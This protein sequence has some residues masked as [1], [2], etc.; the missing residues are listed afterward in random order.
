[1]RILQGTIHPGDHPTGIGTFSQF[2]CDDSIE[3][4][5]NPNNEHSRKPEQIYM[6]DAQKLSKEYHR[7]VQTS[8]KRRILDSDEESESMPS[9]ASSAKAKLSS[10]LNPSTSPGEWLTSR[11]SE[12]LARTSASSGALA[13]RNLIV[14]DEDDEL[15]DTPAKKRASLPNTVHVSDD[16]HDYEQRNMAST[17][18][19]RTSA[20]KSSENVVAVPLQSSIKG[21]RYS[22]GVDVVEVIGQESD[23]EGND[24]GDVWHGS[25]SRSNMQKQ[26]DHILTQCKQISSELQKSLMKW[27]GAGD[28]LQ[29]SS[30]EDV[31]DCVNLVHISQGNNLIRDQDLI[32]ICPSGL[33]LKGYQLVGVNWIKLLHENRVNGVLADDMGLGE[34][35]TVIS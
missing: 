20:Q 18:G 30:L 2:L 13:K 8:N 26:A 21:N 31:H 15:T 16:K 17:V 28:Q 3:T 22:N 10:S 27:S 33:S 24:D 6:M 29:S 32:S 7:S 1:M 12:G 9:A 5:K 19:G 34:S 11:N 35:F 14:L 4:L 25:M 23:D